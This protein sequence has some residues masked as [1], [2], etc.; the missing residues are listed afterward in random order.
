METLGRGPRRTGVQAGIN[1]GQRLVP[2]ISYTR[3]CRY[4]LR[5]QFKV[6]KSQSTLPQGTK[7]PLRCYTNQRHLAHHLGMCQN[8]RIPSKSRGFFVVFLCTNLKTRTLRPFAG[9]R[10]RLRH[11]ACDDLHG[12]RAHGE[13][14]LLFGVRAG[15]EPQQCRD[16]S[17]FTPCRAVELHTKGIDGLVEVGSL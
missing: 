2:F 5:M 6:Q 15:Q 11:E 4:L 16:L 1:K 9:P 17:R 10:A 3:G 7:G 8:R 13:E 12:H 14:A